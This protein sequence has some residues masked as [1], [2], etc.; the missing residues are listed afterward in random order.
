MKGWWV[1]K[2]FRGMAKWLIYYAS[3]CVLTYVAIR[4]FEK[5]LVEEITSLVPLFAIVSM[6]GYA[7]YIRVLD[8]MESSLASMKFSKEGGHA[9]LSFISPGAY[10][11]SA[12]AFV[13]SDVRQIYHQAVST[14]PNR[15]VLQNGRGHRHGCPTQSRIC[16]DAGGDGQNTGVGQ[17]LHSAD[18][19]AEGQEAQGASRFTISLSFLTGAVLFPRR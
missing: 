12:K 3:A 14:G 16:V 1:K 8:N 5:H 17:H 7:V 6:L 11:N 4:V 19:A 18:Q 2:W 13:E 9:S 10:D 15:A